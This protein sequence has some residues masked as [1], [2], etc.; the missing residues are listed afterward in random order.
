[1]K[2]IPIQKFIK[3][4]N[5]VKLYVWDINISQVWVENIQIKLNCCWIIIQPLNDNSFLKKFIRNF[6]P[7]RRLLIGNIFTAFKTTTYLR[8]GPTANCRTLPQVSRV[9]AG[10]KRR[11]LSS[12]SKNLE[13]KF[14]LP[15][16]TYRWFFFI[17]H[18]CSLILFNV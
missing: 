2:Q 17:N 18:I 3:N 4:I 9:Q 12:D 7:S 6:Q 10:R 8:W 13:K 16:S 14:P 11:L 1:M 15:P 5:K